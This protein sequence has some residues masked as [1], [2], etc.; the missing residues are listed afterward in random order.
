MTQ[1]SETSVSLRILGDDLEPEQVSSA[2]GCR[3]VSSWRK[4]DIRKLRNGREATARTGTWIKSVDRKCPGDLNAQIIELMSAVSGS[5]EVWQSLTGRFRADVFCGLFLSEANEG[6]EIAA[7]TLLAL[8]SR[9]IALS[10]DI[11]AIGSDSV[12]SI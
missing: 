5:L 10:F 4:G 8:G 3:P 1:I 11:Y 9:G 12:D 7:Q 6:G 2:L